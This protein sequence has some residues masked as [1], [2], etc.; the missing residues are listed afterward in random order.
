MNYIFLVYN[1]KLINIKK[2]IG[3]ILFKHELRGFLVVGYK[4]F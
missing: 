4:S 3:K 1:I 2:L